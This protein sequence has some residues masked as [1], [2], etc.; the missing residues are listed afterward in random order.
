MGS[1]VA[2]E[3]KDSAA[4][5]A[6]ATGGPGLLARV[7]G[8]G[9]GVAHIVVLYAVMFVN[10]NLLAVASLLLLAPL[11]PGAH[12]RLLAD[13]AAYAWRAFLFWAQ[14]V[15]GLTPVYTGDVDKLLGT[16]TGPK[17]VMGNHLSFTDS[18][19]IYSVGYAAGEEAHIRAFAK[20]SLSYSPVVGWCWSMLNFIFLSRSFE[21][22]KKNI[23]RQMKKLAE[24]SSKYYSTGNYWLTIFP[25]G[26]RCRPDK[27][28]DAQEFSKSRGLP[29]FQHLLVPRTKGLLAT[30]GHDCAIL[31]ETA[32]AV[33]DLT[34]GYPD[35][36]SGGNKVRPS[37]NDLLFGLGR[38]WEV[39]VH[40]RV[41]PMSHVPKDDAEFS[42]WL[43]DTFVEKDKLL[44]F[45]AREG[46]FPGKPRALKA[47]TP[48]ALVANMLAFTFYAVALSAASLAA[49]SWAQARM[50]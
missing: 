39:H 22:D 42:K 49:V 21:K 33:L 31:R 16:Y 25:E 8:V 29:V 14:V 36:R 32:D 15:G 12:H 45:Y 28:K 13:M 26:T 3:A 23:Q 17:L 11:L 37:V 47:A 2:T 6:G 40:I 10:C 5:S 4:R 30:M 38:R 43:M 44:E 1:N 24:R 41:I 34:F 48:A 9:L 19:L 35:R 20:K 7:L 27:L 46:C 18:F 50:A